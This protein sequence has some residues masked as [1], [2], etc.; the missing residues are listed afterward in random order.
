MIAQLAAWAGAAPERK[1][2][3]H[4]DLSEEQAGRTRAGEGRDRAKR[5]DMQYLRADCVINAE[6]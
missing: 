2:W 6:I 1:S 4:H 3:R 5:P